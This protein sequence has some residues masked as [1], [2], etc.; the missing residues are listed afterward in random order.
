MPPIISG[1]LQQGAWEDQDHSSQ[2]D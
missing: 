2:L 1:E